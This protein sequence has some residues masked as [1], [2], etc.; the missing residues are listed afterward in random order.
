MMGA[1]A[2]SFHRIQEEPEVV[3]EVREKPQ[4]RIH[5]TAEAD[6]GLNLDG[7]PTKA[8]NHNN[9]T[10]RSLVSNVD[11]TIQKRTGYLDSERSKSYRRCYNCAWPLNAITV[12]AYILITQFEQPSW[13]VKMQHLRDHGTPTET[14]QYRDF[15]S[16]FCDDKAGT[17]ATFKTY[18][19]PNYV[20]IPLEAGL[21]L[22]LVYFTWVKRQ[23]MRSDSEMQTAWTVQRIFTFVALLDITVQT[24]MW[25]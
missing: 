9:A 7:D 25:T 22:M 20:S 11:G 2:S 10:M 1:S 3:E 15:D 17:I 6:C 19:I 21:L 18:R 4:L 12:T 24:I 13:C 14:N 8:A 16:L 23:F 5:D